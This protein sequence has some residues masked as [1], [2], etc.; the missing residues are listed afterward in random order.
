MRT[1]KEIQEAIEHFNNERETINTEAILD[2]LEND[3][4]YDEIE[5]KY[6]DENDPWTEQSAMKAR[7]FLDGIVELEEVY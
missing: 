6:F 1:V 5:E 2:V 4:D 7:E 3:L